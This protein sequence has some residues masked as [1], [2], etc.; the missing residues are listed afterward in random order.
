MWTH[1]HLTS[2][3]DRPL[4]RIHLLDILLAPVKPVYGEPLHP[5]AKQRTALG[6]FW[7]SGERVANKLIFAEEMGNS[8]IPAVNKAVAWDLYL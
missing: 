3:D 8:E 4:W 6:G 1:P 2:S 5:F 7:G